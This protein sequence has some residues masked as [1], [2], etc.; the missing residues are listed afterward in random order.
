MLT[1]LNFLVAYYPH[2]NLWKKYN[3]V[4]KNG[5]PFDEI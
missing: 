2:F 1:K 4:Y 3:L 5:Q